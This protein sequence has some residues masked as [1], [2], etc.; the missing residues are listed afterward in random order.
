MN[1]LL[2]VIFFGCVV[3]LI[4]LLYTSRKLQTNLGV[5]NTIRKKAL[6]IEQSTQS[7]DQKLI[8]ADKLL[9][10]ALKSRCNDSQSI[11][12]LLKKHSNIFARHELNEIWSAHK[13]RNQLAH[14]IHFSASNQEK[15]IAVKTLLKYSRKI[16]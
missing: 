9:E 3:I 6:E 14:D 1:P 16:V 15:G 2:L 7:L 8:Q 13:L 4:V 5:K 11:G 10:F 12:V